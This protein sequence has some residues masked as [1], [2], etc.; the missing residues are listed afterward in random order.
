MMNDL[1]A[2]I[3]NDLSTSYVYSEWNGF[4]N[5]IDFITYDPNDYKEM[6]EIIFKVLSRIIGY[7]Y[8]IVENNYPD[9]NTMKIISEFYSIEI[10]YLLPFEDILP[11]N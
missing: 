6:K 3:F 2:K 5:Y 1:M 7:S 9:R 4:L 11:N 10:E 8:T